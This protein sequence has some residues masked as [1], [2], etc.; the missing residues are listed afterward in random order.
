MVWTT[1]FMAPEAYTI[2][3]ALSGYVLNETPTQIHLR[4]AKAYAKF[5]K[6]S[7]KAASKLLASGF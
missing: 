1:Q 4:A 3:D 5:Q 2:H 7:V 6:C